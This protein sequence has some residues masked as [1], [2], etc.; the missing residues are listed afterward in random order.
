MINL[1]WTPI[2]Y[3]E[4]WKTDSKGEVVLLGISGCYHLNKS[5]SFIWEKLDGTNTIST[6]I[7]M[8]CSFFNINRNDVIIDIL[9]LLKRWEKDD[10][11]VLNYNPL[12]PVKELHTIS[13]K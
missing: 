9:E 3:M 7:D 5:A 10:L 4:I 8:V 2:R 1:K 11:I 6:I 12:N 13:A